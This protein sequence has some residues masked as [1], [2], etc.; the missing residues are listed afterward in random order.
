MSSMFDL[1]HDAKDEKFELTEAFLRAIRRWE[2]AP[3]NQSG[4]DKT[5]VERLIAETRVHFRRAVRLR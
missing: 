3:H 1:P 4:Q 5:W 2:D